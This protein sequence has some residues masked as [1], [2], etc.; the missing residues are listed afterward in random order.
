MKSTLSL[1]ALLALVCQVLAVDVKNKYIIRLKDT[2][3]QPSFTAKLKRAV[4]NENAR[5]S[6]TIEHKVVHEYD[7]GGGK[8]KGYAGQFSPEFVAR[9]VKNGEV[10]SVR[11][12]GVVKAYGVQNSPPSWGL[13]RISEVYL[14]VS[15]PYYYPDSAGAGVN[16]YVI[17]TG[18]LTTHS[19]FEGRAIW[20][21]TACQ[22]CANTDDNGHGSH[23]AGTIGSKTYGVAKKT[24]LIAVK[25]LNGKGE[26]SDADVIAGIQ[27]A[28]KDAKARGKPAVA[29]MSL[30][31][32]KSQDLNDA[33]EA[34]IA[35]GLTFSVAAGNESQDACNTSP[36]SAPNVISVAASD[37]TDYL[38]DFSN[39]GTCTD[40]IAPGV[41]IKSTWNNGGT[42]TISGTSM[43]CPHVSGVVALILADNPTFTPAQILAKLKELA[44][45]GK[46]KGSLNSTPNLLLNNGANAQPPT[47]STTKSTTT[48]TKTT[49]ST[50][51]KTTTTAKPT[52][53][54]T[55]TTPTPTPTQ[56]SCPWWDPWCD[57]Y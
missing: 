38:A 6:N 3:D 47:T 9:L 19:D 56:P 53:T 28:T 26:G 40:I 51:T 30:G 11:P 43:A 52:P 45:V 39:Y 29:S 57:E 20:G 17:D 35:D 49:T 1:V 55:T 18:I 32:D 50:V 14:D 31:G 34:A 13:P 24:T 2:T 54:K 33:V 21:Y 15:K 27:W 12:D 41:N 23:C 4:E 42:N 25:V 22:G 44:S 16:A 8:F 37:K 36:A 7:L 46:I 5:E 10:A 48:V